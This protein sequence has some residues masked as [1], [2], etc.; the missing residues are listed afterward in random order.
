MEVFK[1]AHDIQAEEKM[2]AV[3][4]LSSIPE[5]VM[6]VREYCL[7]AFREAERAFGEHMGADFEKALRALDNADFSVSMEDAA[8]TISTRTSNG[9][10]LSLSV[11]EDSVVLMLARDGKEDVITYKEGDITRKRQV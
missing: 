3:N 1:N 5:K 7:L 9:T 2:T 4:P 8:H 11:D 6:G 10:L